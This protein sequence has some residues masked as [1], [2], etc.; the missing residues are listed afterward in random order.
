MIKERYDLA[1]GRIQEI[2]NEESVIERYRPFFVAVSEFVLMLHE[3]KGEI[4]SGEYHKKSLE[5]LKKW[6]H[7]LYE[8]IL[9]ENYNVSYANPAYAVAQLGE[10][11]GQML[12]FLYTEIRGA[13]A[14]TFEGKE[15]YLA[16]LCELFV[17]IYNAFEGEEIPEPKAI[18]DII[19]WFASDYCD[20]FV[21]DRIREQIDPECSF[22]T[23]IICNS[24]LNDLRY[25]YWF[26]EYIG[27]NEFKTAE[28][29]CKL[30]EDKIQ[31]MADV[32][33]EGYRVGFIV[34]KKDLSKKSTVCIR[35]VLGFEKMIKKAIEN[36]EKMGLKTIIYR[37]S[38]S[39]L[40]KSQHQKVG[41]YGGIANK[42]Y[43]YDHKDDQALFLNK[44]YAER[45]LEVI[46]CAYESQKDLA[47]KHAGPAVVEV[48]G[49]Q[50][51]SPKQKEEA[52][53]IS[54]RQE[55]TQRFFAGKSGQ[56]TNEYIPG[57]ERSYTIIAYPVPEI[58][59]QYEE[60]FEEIIK[61][62]TLDAEVYTQIQ[63][64]L[65]DALDQG[66]YVRILGAN[67]NRTDLT[68]QLWRLNDPEKETIFENCVADVNIPVGEV[69]TS[70]VLEGTNGVLHVSKVF[71]DELQYEDLELTFANGMIADYRCGNFERES[72]GKKYVSDNILHNHPTL[73]LGEFAIGTNTTAYVV[74]KKYNIEDK[75]PILIAEKT[76]PHFAVGDTC[77]SWCEDVKMFNPNG[78]EVVARENSVSALRKENV[79]KAYYNCHT[80]ITIPYDE[81]G[82]ITVVTKDGKEIDLLKDGRFVLQGTEI[83][84]EPLNNR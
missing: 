59:E 32:Y 64:T 29:F 10:E 31:K 52:V 1:I 45:K 19:Y 3:L 28:H 71:L 48:F 74:A 41:Y 11:M 27:E 61:I 5:D 66:E 53:S 17:E 21:A 58:G 30:D 81:L 75:M 33:T 70:P 46:K 55:E 34:T 56:L 77:Y 72:D 42:Q 22:A 26:G 36:F 44:R 65:I 54:K 47:A 6:N 69:F 82:S 24:D 76:G 38:V 23:D 67:G 68:V 49:E 84:N 4:E 50:P 18:K 15:E 7:R 16:I 57:D 9:P 8:D 60:I 25:L 12:S 78:K 63:Q 37:S 40:T 43:E 35:Y 20:V 2:K 62:N 80:D 51:F 79:D 13:I 83:L 14:Y 73:A 39:A